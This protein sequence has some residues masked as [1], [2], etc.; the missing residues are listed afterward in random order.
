LATSIRPL[1]LSA[2]VFAHR[3]PGRRMLLKAGDRAMILAEIAVGHAATSRGLSG[4]QRVGDG[5]G[6]LFVMSRP[7]YLS[8]WMRGT[9]VPLSIAF[10]ADDG[11]ILEIHD[12]EPFS[13][14]LVRSGTPVRMA[15]EV[16]QGWF[17]RRGVGVGSAVSVAS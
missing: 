12:M 11:T 14:Q 15:L 5:E 2:V 16:P 4:R 1:A 6:M 9:A 10:L 7:D 13:E 8:F 17:G 3:S